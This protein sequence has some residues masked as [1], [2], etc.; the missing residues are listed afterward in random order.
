MKRRTFLSSLAAG[1]ASLPLLSKATEPPVTFKVIPPMDYPKGRAPTHW[2]APKKPSAVNLDVLLECIAMVE[3]GNNPRLVG[4]WGEVG[5][6]QL[7]PSVIQQHAGLNLIHANTEGC[8]WIAVKHILWLD[9]HLPRESITENFSR[10]LPLAF[11][12]RAG[13]T[14]W[15]NYIEASKTTKIQRETAAY[16]AR[17]ANLYRERMNVKFSWSATISQNGNVSH[18]SS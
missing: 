10:E 18:I 14:G 3:T 1:A 6:H 15:K 16:A 5:R 13:L 2:G 4:P 7:M 12:W 17:V 8:D 9:R 11:A